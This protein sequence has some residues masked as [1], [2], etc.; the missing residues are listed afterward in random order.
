VDIKKKHVSVVNSKYD[1]FGIYAWQL[2]NGNLLQDEDHNTL[3]ISS[4]F[5]DLYRISKISNAARAYGYEEGSPVFLAGRRKI[6]SEEYER[7]LSRLDSGLIP[8]DYDLAAYEEEFAA[9]ESLG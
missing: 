1:R 5:G 9:K 6:T 3:S 8:D 2:P 7:Q 4:E